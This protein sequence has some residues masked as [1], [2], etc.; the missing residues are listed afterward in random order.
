MAERTSALHR[1][2]VDSAAVDGGA[3]RV[4]GAQAH[5]LARV[6]RLRPGELVI[7]VDGMGTEHVVE[8]TAVTP[9]LVEGSVRETRPSV[10]EPRLRIALYQGLVTREKLETVIQKG[11]EMGVSTF[12]PVRCERSIVARGEAVDERRLDRWRR[13]AT[14]AAEQSGRGAVP[15]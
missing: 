10:G 14:E 8:L 11:T 4:E 2:F 12:V 7:L 6:L 5:Q 13:I 3:A 1:F 9:T 15:V